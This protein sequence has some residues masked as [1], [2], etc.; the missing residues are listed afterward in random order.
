[1]TA[2]SRQNQD[3]DVRAILRNLLLKPHLVCFAP[4]LAISVQN[5]IAEIGLAGCS[6][7]LTMAEFSNPT[8]NP[9]PR[10]SSL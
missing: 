1:M 9:K 4:V 2:K 10:P 7:L 6:K 5:N 3:F 8:A